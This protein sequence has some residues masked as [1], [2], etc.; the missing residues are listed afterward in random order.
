MLKSSQILK[1]CFNNS[2]INGNKAIIIPKATNT[3]NK[4]KLN[5]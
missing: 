3:V 2:K 1:V 4:L 5:L